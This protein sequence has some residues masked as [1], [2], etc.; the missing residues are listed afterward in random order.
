MRQKK[1]KDKD[2]ESRNQLGPIHTLHSSY[3][4]EKY[5]VGVKPLIVM[6]SELKLE[7]ID[8]QSELVDNDAARDSCAPSGTTGLRRQ[9][10]PSFLLHVNADVNH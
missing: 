8:I 7:V 2:T 9:G 3:K 10:A 1:A 4:S 5:Q 6:V